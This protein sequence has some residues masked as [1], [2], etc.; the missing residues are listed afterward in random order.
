MVF[1]RW[2]NGTQKTEKFKLNNPD[3]TDISDIKNHL[4]KKVSIIASIDSVK[5]IVTKKGE[6]MAF[7]T[8]SDN[9]GTTVLVI[10]PELYKEVNNF[11]K[12]EL[13]KVNGKVE[14]RFDEYQIICNEIFR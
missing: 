4:N 2:K 5:E 13:I 7:V 6:V 14:K 1:W 8:G 3:I 10:F 11:K 9:T 12:N